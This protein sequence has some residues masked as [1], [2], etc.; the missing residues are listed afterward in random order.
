MSAAV[1]E[2]EAT[3]TDKYQATVPSSV[4]K[5]LGLQKRDRIV[6]EIRDGEVVLRRADTEGS[7]DVIQAFLAFLAADLMAGNAQPF[8]DAQMARIDDLVGD[9]DVDLDLPLDPDDD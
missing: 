5:A 2:A 4:R 8:D 9:A 3:L 7:D 1:L 6:Y